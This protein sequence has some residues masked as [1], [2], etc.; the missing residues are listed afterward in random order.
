MDNSPTCLLC[1]CL[2]WL[3]VQHKLEAPTWG[4]ACSLLSHLAATP[5]GTAALLKGGNW[6][7]VGSSGASQAGM[8]PA[9]Q[10]Q[11]SGAA[12]ASSGAGGSEALLEGVQKV[13]R[14]LVSA[15]PRPRD[16]PRLLDL[17]QVSEGLSTWKLSC[18]RCR[19][20]CHEPCTCKCARAG[21][22][23][24]LVACDASTYVSRFGPVW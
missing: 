1:L 17:M 7:R 9:G 14:D 19:L 2:P 15:G 11:G 23:W 12:G 6:V 20:S 8:V 13:V 16:L 24:S 3:D 18:R 4:L 21:L 10:T 5:D 22:C